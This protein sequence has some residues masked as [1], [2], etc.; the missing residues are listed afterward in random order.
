MHESGI[1]CAA[2]LKDPLSYQPFLPENAGQKPTRFVL[3]KH[4]GSKYLRKPETSAR[5]TG[6]PIWKKFKLN[7]LNHCRRTS[8]MINDLHHRHDKPRARRQ[9]AN[10]KWSADKSGIMINKAMA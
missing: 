10:A 1:H 5:K 6:L 3:G 7:A 2:L 9:T 8:K 4:S